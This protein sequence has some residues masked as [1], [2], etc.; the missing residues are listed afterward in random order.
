MKV[1][2]NLC[3]MLI[4]VSYPHPLTDTVLL[5]YWPKFNSPKEVMF[6]M[7]TEEILDIIDVAEFAKI[8]KVSACM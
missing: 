8:M 6:V 7:E 3:S 2:P 5:K 4:I 1:V